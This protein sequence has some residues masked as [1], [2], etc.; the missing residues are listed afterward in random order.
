MPVS[1]HVY[2][3]AV[4]FKMTE[5]VEQW[6]CIKFSIMLEY[7]STETIQMRQKAAAM[8]NWWLA[9][10]SQLC[11]CSCITSS[12][13][14]FVKHQINQVTQPHYNPI[15]W[16][17]A[18][19]KIKITFEREEISDH[20]WDSGKC[21]GATNGDWENCVRSRDSYFEGDWDVIVLC[22]KCLVFYI[23]FN[24]RLYFSYYI[25]AYLLER[26]DI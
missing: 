12:T 9:S 13:Q 15:W 6:I 20:W 16:L 25:P 4:T 26:S 7:S 14:F 10:S 11:T 2:C 19:P 17:L 3:V 24:K 22:T 8:G 5:W 1:E 23:F 18:F 21:N